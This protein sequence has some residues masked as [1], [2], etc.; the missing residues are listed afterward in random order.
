MHVLTSD[1]LLNEN[2]K[3]GIISRTK[4]EL[5]LEI[6]V[7]QVNWIRIELWINFWVKFSNFHIFQQQH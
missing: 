2:I 5:E 1:I 6:T 3:L 7:Q 4:I